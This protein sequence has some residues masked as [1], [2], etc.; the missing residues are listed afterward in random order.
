MFRE[1]FPLNVHSEISMANEGVSLQTKKNIL[2]VALA[3]LSVVI[4]YIASQFLKN[5]PFMIV[6]GIAGLA[7]GIGVSSF[8]WNK[9]LVDLDMEKFEES[10]SNKIFKFFKL[11]LSEGIDSREVEEV[12]AIRYLTGEY[13]I[14]LTISIGNITNL[15]EQLTEEFFDKLF[16]LCHK[17]QI[18][19]KIFTLKDDWDSS[20]M[21]LLYLR[22]LSRN[23]DK[24]L[25]KTLSRI[26][27]HQSEVFSKSFV[28]R[29]CFVFYVPRSKLNKL[30]MITGFVSS[31]ISVNLVMSSIR[32]IKWQDRQSAIK[33]SCDYLGTKLIDVSPLADKE[34]KIVLDIRK[35]VRPHKPDTFF[36]DQR[37]AMSAVDT[38]AVFIRQSSYSSGRRG[39]K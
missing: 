39:K 16:L 36:T 18:K 6:G 14:F 29:L 1:R 30:K 32:E 34:K 19:I 27:E 4:A 7:L 12:Q 24:K 37:T 15:G 9:F 5:T 8:I 17:Q 3:G 13:A 31:W 21:H 10:R 11:S 23:H 28:N 25:R 22:R 35:L 38:N 26:D 33:L 2:R 20:D